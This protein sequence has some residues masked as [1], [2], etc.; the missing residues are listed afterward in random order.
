MRQYQIL[1]LLL[2]VAAAVFIPAAASDLSLSGTS[3]VIAGNDFALSISGGDLLG[4]V[5]LSLTSGD[6][7]DLKLLAGKPNVSG[8]TSSATVKLDSSYI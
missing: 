4:T 2:L 6:R 1:S 3:S 7:P 5:T 8:S